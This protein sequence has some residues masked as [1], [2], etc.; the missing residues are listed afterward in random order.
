MTPQCLSILE[1]LTSYDRNVLLSSGPQEH[2][3]IF[4]EIY[5]TS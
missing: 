3:L 2:D 5:I 1:L 4:A